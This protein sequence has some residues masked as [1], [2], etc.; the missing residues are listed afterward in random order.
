[1]WADLAR[2]A[3]CTDIKWWLSE[4]ADDEGNITIELRWIPPRIIVYSL[5][6]MAKS[7]STPK[8]PYPIIPWPQISKD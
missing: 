7:N 2:A 1:M 5:D 8:R 4:A 6:E 3:G